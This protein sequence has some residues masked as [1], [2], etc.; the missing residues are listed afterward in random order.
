MASHRG[1]VAKRLF[2]ILLAGLGLA[3]VAP[4]MLLLAALI[5]LES[6]G[7]VF[8][9]GVRV[10]K[11]GKRFRI[12]KLRTMVADSEHTDASTTS[13]SDPRLTRVG[14][15]IRKAKLDELSQLIN[16]LRGD[17]SIVGP[18]PQVEWAVESYREDEREI[19]RL[20]PGITDWASI[21]FHNE[22]EII[23]RSGIEDADEAYLRLIHPLKTRYQLKY[24]RERSFWIDIKIVASTI[25]TLLS[26][27]LG[28]GP[29]G[30][31]DMG[32][33]GLSGENESL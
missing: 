11:D 8:Y 10:G 26:T 2:D 7:P 15:V 16:V 13:A 9:R 19:L 30:V 3:A 1:T 17:M 4:V 33:A 24:L 27:R 22:E 25:L 28:G 20:R 18:R 6:P 5:K 23:A 31:P 21:A 32:S 14:R 29:I 12:F